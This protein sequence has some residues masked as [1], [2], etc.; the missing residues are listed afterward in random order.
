MVTT[1]STGFYGDFSALS[2]L[3]TEARGNETKAL[4]QAAQQFE[5][6]F[7]EMMLKS[8]RSASFGDDL[9]SSDEVEFYQGMF[10]QQLSVQLSQGKG[11][12]LADMLVQQLTRSGLSSAATAT[13]PADTAA[14]TTT[15][16][17][18]ENQSSTVTATQPVI[19][20]T[21]SAATAT[22]STASASLAESPEEFVRCVW[23]HAQQAAR[24][25]G[26]DPSVLVAHAALETGWGK[27]VPADAQGSSL[28]LFGIKA[29]AAWQGNSTTSL[30][31]EYEQG[32]P[33]QQLADFKRYDSLSDCFADYAQ[34]LGSRSRYAGAVNAGGNAGQFA[35]GLQRGGYATDPDYA[36]KL[37]SVARSV[38]KLLGAT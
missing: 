20:N 25:L 35:T 19:S 23:P 34:L 36:N 15:S 11:M 3:K 8:M 2:A 22:T 6:L 27:H 32:S 16:P 17:V 21:T 31:T 1:S 38:S 5:S 18:A 30:T 14:A 29:T 4:R 26:V 33:V 28:N 13:A 24:Q 7:T 10:D 9:T 12:G 37:Q